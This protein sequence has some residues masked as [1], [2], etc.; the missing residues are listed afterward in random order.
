MR[1]RVKYDTL[2]LP[3]CSFVAYDTSVKIIL[4][5]TIFIGCNALKNYTN[6]N[7]FFSDTI[8][9]H[10]FYVINKYPMISEAYM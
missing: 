3:Q 4:L 7:N 9:Y 6:S 1:V 10:L 2:E 5:F 8:M